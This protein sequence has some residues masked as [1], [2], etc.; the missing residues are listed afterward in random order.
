MI[1]SIRAWKQA[2]VALLCSGALVACAVS[3][4][5]A[6]DDEDD[7]GRGG[8]RVVDDAG[9]RDTG[10]D[11]DR[12][13]AGGSADAGTPFFPDTTGDAG[14]AN[15]AG[16]Q[17]AT[18]DTGATADA[19]D[20][21]ASDPDATVADVSRPDVD[22]GEPCISETFEPGAIVRPVDIVWAIDASPSMDDEIARIE[23][24]MNDFAQRIGASGLDYRVVV[25]GSDRDQYLP[26]EA[27]RFNEICIPPP[28]SAAP[29]CPDVD[30][31]RYLHVREPIH[32][33]EALA[34]SL[35]TFDE[36][37]AFLRPTS[38]K[39]FIYVTDDDERRAS[40]ADEFRA[41]VRDEPVMGD[42]VYVHSIVDFIGYDPNCFLD[43]NC[44]CG[45]ARGEVYLGLTESTGGLSASLCQDDW[46]P[47]FDALEER[48]T[49]AVEVPC[50]FIVPDPGDRYDVDYGE[51]VVRKLA[52]VSSDV[53]RVADASACTAAGGWYFDDPRTPTRLLLCPASCGDTGFG[54]EV[55]LECFREKV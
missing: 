1:G 19:S 9:A 2:A 20:P 6:G 35:T 29:T 14:A 33:K 30:S 22:S 28:L 48:V 45:D 36:Y 34:E 41:L 24:Q 15:D 32:S 55:E 43:D 50:E 54:I 27:H 10:L 31:D 39:H 8:E 51:V 13:D 12:S 25:I 38:I 46:T 44:S 18:N 3:E 47:I 17:D 7:I 21:D 49:D 5:G 52:G 42:R 11:P 26:A 37:R 40:A 53:P 23:A 4:S 16:G